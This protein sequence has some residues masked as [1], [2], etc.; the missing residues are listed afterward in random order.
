MTGAFEGTKM[1]AKSQEESKV[2]KRTEIGSFT[3]I[4]GSELEHVEKWDSY[5]CIESREWVESQCRGWETCDYCKG[6][7]KTAP[8]GEPGT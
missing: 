3:C 8:S 7:P 6:R 1:K 5:Y 2:H 4:C